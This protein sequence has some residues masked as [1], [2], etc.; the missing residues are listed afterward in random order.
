[1]STFD[2]WETQFY[3]DCLSYGQDSLMHFR[4]KGSKN[5]VRR[6]QNPDG[7]WTDLGLKERRIREGFGARIKKKIRKAVK[8]HRAAKAAARSARAERIEKFKERLRKNNPKNLSDAELKAGI[9]RLK[10]EKEYRELNKNPLL[11]TGE[12]LVNGYFKAKEAKLERDRKRTEL[13]VKA[14]EAETKRKEAIAEIQKAKSKK[15]EHKADVLDNIIGG[16]RKLKAK[17]EWHE[18]KTKSTIRGALRQ[19]AHD[20]LNKEGQRLVR[21]MGDQSLIMRGGRK[22]KKIAK[23]GKQKAATGAMKAARRIEMA[24]RRHKINQRHRAGITP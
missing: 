14:K 24:Y 20:V 1:M 7:T 21:D 10:M 2:G 13:F 4:T 12:K 23:A 18:V 9:E 15:W 3:G 6:Y 8:Q 19:T 5:G 17:K 11:A 22:V 16:A